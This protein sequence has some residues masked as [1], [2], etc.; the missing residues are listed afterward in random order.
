MDADKDLIKQQEQD[1]AKLEDSEADLNDK[2]KEVQAA[3]AKLETMQKDLDKQLNE[4]DKLFDEAK[5]S[6]K[7]TAKAISE[8]K[9]EASEL[10]NQK[11]ILKL[12]KHASKKNKKQ[13]LL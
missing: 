7:K 3:L 11:Q 6:Q 1:K 10:A 4:K 13:R 8:L 12:N 2:L 9:S 5:A